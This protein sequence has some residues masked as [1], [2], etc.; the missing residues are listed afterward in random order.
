[1]TM[2]MTKTRW[3]VPIIHEYVDGEKVK[4]KTNF[5]SIPSDKYRKKILLHFLSFLTF[6]LLCSGDL[7]EA[8]LSRYNNLFFQGFQRFFFYFFLKF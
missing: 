3:I 8:F 6:H 4:L 7:N 2:T 5:S 1:M